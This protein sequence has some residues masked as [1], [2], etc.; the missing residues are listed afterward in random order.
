M[1]V[2]DRVDLAYTRV[3]PL[4]V[5]VFGVAAVYYVA[6]SYGLGVIALVFGKEG[7]TQVLGVASTSPFV[8]GIGVPLIPIG[9]ISLEAYDVEGRILRYWRSSVS[10]TLSKLPLIGQVIDWLWPTPTREPLH[11]GADGLGGSIDFLAR[12]ISSGLLL[13]FAAFVVGRVCF[14]SVKS[15][16]GRVVLVCML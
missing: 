12:N 2:L 10:P 11:T 7:A 5:G 15:N 16:Y 14:R 1:V 8:I 3:C 9:L 6:F 13:P 4:G